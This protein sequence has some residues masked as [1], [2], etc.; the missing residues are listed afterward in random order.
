[1]QHHTRSPIIAQLDRTRN[2][3][4]TQPIVLDQRAL[5]VVVHRHVLERGIPRPF[6]K[7][8]HRRRPVH[9]VAEQDERPRPVVGIVQGRHEVDVRADERVGEVGGDESQVEGAR[10][11]LGGRDVDIGVVVLTEGDDLELLGT[12]AEC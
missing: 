3:K 4:L 7:V 10:D 11:A 9:W 5:R 8:E 1:M 12:I 2:G 6:E